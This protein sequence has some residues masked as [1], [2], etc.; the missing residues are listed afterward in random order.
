[1][2]SAESYEV[3]RQ[4]QEYGTDNLALKMD[5]PA[6][7]KNLNGM[8]Q[9][10]RGMPEAGKTDKFTKIRVSDDNKFIVIP[11]DLWKFDK[12]LTLK[13]APGTQISYDNDNNIL[14]PRGETMRMVGQADQ[15]KAIYVLNI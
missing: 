15:N 8:M 11:A 13:I 5:A 14:I 1:M 7:V 2:N 3:L 4:A 10:S 6:F 12:N 9:A